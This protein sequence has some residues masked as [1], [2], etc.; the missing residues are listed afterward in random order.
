MASSLWDEYK[1]QLAQAAPVFVK[2]VEET[3]A[4]SPL[5]DKVTLEARL[6][7]RLADYE[8]FAA[9]TDGLLGMS[10]G[11]HTLDD[12]FLGQRPGSLYIHS[13]APHGGKT[14]L[15]LQMMYR[16]AR[17]FKEN[18]VVLF[19]SLDQN[20]SSMTDR[21]IA[22]HTGQSSTVFTP[23]WI[24]WARGGANWPWMK[25][26]AIIGHDY[27][28]QEQQPIM[29]NVFTWYQEAEAA[30]FKV[31]E[32]YLDY[33]QVLAYRLDV[34]NPVR[35]VTTACILL[36]MLATQLHIPIWAAS[37]V[38]REGKIRWSGGADHQADGIILS[39]PQ[40]NWEVGEAKRGYQFTLQKNRTGNA[41]FVS[42][43]FTMILDVSTGRMWD[44]VDVWKA[45]QEWL[46]ENFTQQFGYRREG[47]HWVSRFNPKRCFNVQP[48][49]PTSK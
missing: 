22:M 43:E 27:L 4:D 36:K 44:C 42:E 11:F 28:Y 48:T 29:D 7:A 40:E 31:K 17:T 8:L 23:K 2:Q 18:E 19:F 41:V 5:W 30:G 38:S 6:R 12:V 24:D 49:K 3:A 35:A 34:D 14:S 39:G 1:P 47:D 10:T 25:H 16:Q 9:S 37:S 32:I 20:P 26:I 33:L 15:M 46:D 45:K 21:L 13:A